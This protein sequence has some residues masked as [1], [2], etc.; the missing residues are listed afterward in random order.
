MNWQKLKNQDPF[1]TILVFILSA[2]GLLIIYSTT[3]TYPSESSLGQMLPKQILFLILGFIIYFLLISIDLSWFE[4][5][6]FIKIMYILILGL[7]IVVKFFGET[8][9]GT[10]RWIDIG[11]FSLQPAEYAK[12]AII[13]L[14]AKNLN[15]IKLYESKPLFRKNNKKIPKAL[16]SRP[17]AM[18]LLKNALLVIPL[19][20][21]I[22]IQPSL[23]NAMISLSLWLLMILILFPKPML[24]TKI[25]MVLSLGISLALQIFEVRFQSPDF[26]ITQYQSINWLATIIILIVLIA[27]IIALKI[28]PKIFIT[29]LIL[30]IVIIVGIPNIWNGV[31]TDYQKQRVLTYFE[32]PES[33][34]TGS[35]YQIIQSRI[36]IGS[37]MLTGRGYLQ[38]TQSSLS[39]LTQS[40]TDFAFAAYAEQFGFIGV[41]ILLFI[42]FLLLI[43]I[44]RVARNSRNNFGK[45][46]ALGICL[47]LFLHIFINIGMNMGL[48]PVTGIP[49]PLISYGGSATVM[50]LICLGLV[51][52]VQSSQRSVDIADNL[53]VTSRSLLMN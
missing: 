11:F 2:I 44:L 31:M 27:S 46:V 24:L 47:L 38:G 22:L 21:L 52:S 3:F 37:G 13:L 45:Y 36:A 28:S 51:Q 19:I 18:I 53:M 5:E 35:G 50:I 34:P 40:F 30:G 14:S 43:R 48:L 41:L 17:V 15:D 33:D 8:R 39:V 7:L 12:I 4:D 9:A 10:N 23:G 49:L 16:L 32:G 26:V 29:F 20:V 6:G 25:V 42:Y 1:I